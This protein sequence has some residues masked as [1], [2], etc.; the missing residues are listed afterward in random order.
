MERAGHFMQRCPA[1][2]DGRLILELQTSD[3][4]PGSRIG[5]TVDR[6]NRTE[7]A[8]DRTKVGPRRCLRRNLGSEGGAD[9]I[10]LVWLRQL[11]TVECIREFHA[12]AELNALLDPESPADAHILGGIPE[13]A[14]IANCGE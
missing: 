11:D 2:H 10:A 5:C 14:V 6:H 3:E 4:Q 8:V 12:S 7:A 1:F 13:A 9:S